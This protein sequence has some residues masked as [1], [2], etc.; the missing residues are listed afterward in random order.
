MPAVPA[1][2]GISFE[3][4]GRRS[5]HMGDEALEGGTT[6]GSSSSSGASPALKSWDNDDYHDIR[7]KSCNRG[8]AKHLANKGNL[9]DSD[10]RHKRHL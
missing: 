5:A 10:V 1:A 2:P 4:E 7:R 8:V 6:V 9:G 3:T